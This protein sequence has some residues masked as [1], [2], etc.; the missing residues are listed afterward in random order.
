MSRIGKKPVQ[1]PSGV[2]VELS[3]SEFKA[4]G[5]AAQLTTKLSREVV[6]KKDG[7]TIVVSPRNDSK[8]ARA[9]WGLM[10][11]IIA[12]TLTGVS[13][14]FKKTLEVNGV[15]Y[16]ASAD[17]SILAL[18]VGFSHPIRYAFPEGVEFK[19]PKP[20]II[21]ITG[22]DNQKVGQVAAEI[23][24]FRPPEPYKGKGIKYDDERIIRKEGKKK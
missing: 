9:A 22:S 24:Q 1:I 8:E 5:K 15:G 23:R 12:N 16:R 14:G 10:R 20:T 13:E 3:E 11:S 2:Q 7:E 4:K 18:D 6:V 21:E 19:C 17:G